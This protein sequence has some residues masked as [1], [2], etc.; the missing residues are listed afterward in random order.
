MSQQLPA[1]WF[2]H[3]Q[4]PA[5]AYTAGGEMKLI[6]ELVG[7]PPAPP[8]PPQAASAQYQQPAP[9]AQ[10]Q[11]APWGEADMGAMDEDLAAA[12]QAA[13]NRGG[14][15]KEDEIYIDFPELPKPRSKGQK[16]H[17]FTRLLPPWERGRPKPYIR[18]HMLWIPA[19]FWPEQYDKQALPVVS[20]ETKHSKVDPGPDPIQQA[21]NEIKAAGPTDEV[22]NKIRRMRA[23]RIY[24]Q[25]Y[26]VENVNRHWMQVKDEN[27]NPVIDA[28]G[29]YQYVLQPGVVTMGNKLHAKVLENQNEYK[30]SI[31]S[32]ERGRPIKLVKTVT[33]PEPM[34]I[35]YDC[36][37]YD[38]EPIPEQMRPMLYNLIDLEARYVR[39][40]PRNLME[41]CAAMIARKLGGKGPSEQ[42][43]VQVQRPAPAQPPQ[44][45]AQPPQQPAPQ[46]A[47]PGY[48]Q[49]GPP[50]AP[51]APPQA[52]PQP[53]YQAQPPGPPPA[54]PAPPQGAPQPPPAPQN[55]PPAPP[56]APPGAQPPPVPQN[57][58]PAPA[59][60]SPGMAHI[61]P[62]SLED[63]ERMAGIR[64]S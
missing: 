59:Q 30:T 19:E 51:P 28:Q 33:G 3:P 42:V 21:L 13:A 25:G 58:A 26:D 2:P 62:T 7:A 64:S 39:Y 14:R 61:A 9:Q 34:N 37:L 24:W 53:Q 10:P 22:A 57:A 6:A 23:T 5:W 40:K 18:V 11:D 4:D 8:A 47:P 35:D 29:Q 31:T 1:G 60:P 44:Q 36:F 38:P 15:N 43:P 20:Y 52:V 56:V 12:K 49:Q 45:P 63:M 17:V 41:Q 27:G 55:A 32:V 16:T 54:P 48:P 50:Q 46:A